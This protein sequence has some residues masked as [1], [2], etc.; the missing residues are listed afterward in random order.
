MNKLQSITTKQQAIFVDALSDYAIKNRY[1]SPLYAVVS[2]LFGMRS[3]EKQPDIISFGFGKFP[4]SRRFQ[5]HPLKNGDLNKYNSDSISSFAM[6]ATW[7]INCFPY[8]I[9]LHHLDLAN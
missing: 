2:V 3:S 8:S 4:G 7:K 6:L 9:R 1:T 5:T